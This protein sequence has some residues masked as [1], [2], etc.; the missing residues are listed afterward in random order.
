[1]VNTLVVLIYSSKRQNPSVDNGDVPPSLLKRLE[2]VLT[3]YFLEG[4]GASEGRWQE[5]AEAHPSMPVPTL[6]P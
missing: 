4:V 6:P 2:A 1:M 3:K 5:G